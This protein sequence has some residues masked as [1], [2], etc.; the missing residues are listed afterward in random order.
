MNK[1]KEMHRYSSF[2]IILNRDLKKFGDCFFFSSAHELSSNSISKLSSRDI[3]LHII[4]YV[5]I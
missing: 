2:F 5:L 1:I 4:K 3:V